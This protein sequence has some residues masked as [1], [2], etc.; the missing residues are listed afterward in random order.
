M[1]AGVRTF[2]AHIVRARARLGGCT[3]F[4]VKSLDD[5]IGNI[6]VDN[7]I[8]YFLILLLSPKF[9]AVQGGTSDCTLCFVDIEFIILFSIRSL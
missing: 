5:K 4:N 9:L 8:V 6:F 1:N 3:H 2:S 7:G